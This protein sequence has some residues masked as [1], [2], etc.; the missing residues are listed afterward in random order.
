MTTIGPAHR[1]AAV[2]IKHMLFGA[3]AIFAVTV[4]AGVPVGTALFYGLFLACPLMMIWMMI[5]LSSQ[6]HGRGQSSTHHD[7]GLP[8]ESHRPGISGHQ[9]PTS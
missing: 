9:T 1:A 5:G 3:A 7:D 2:H 4:V 6:G 8:E